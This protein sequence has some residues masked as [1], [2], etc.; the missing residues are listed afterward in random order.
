MNGAWCKDQGTLIKLI[1][2]QKI[3][4][5]DIVSINTI[6]NMGTEFYLFFYQ[7]VPDEV[8]H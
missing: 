5:E 1:N 8:G 3:K 4:Q 2:D 7:D 6:F